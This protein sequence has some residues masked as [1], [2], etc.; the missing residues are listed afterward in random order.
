MQAGQHMDDTR[1]E[2][3]PQLTNIQRSESILINGHVHGFLLVVS[4][5]FIQPVH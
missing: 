2:T 4:F 3:G 5:F 1:I